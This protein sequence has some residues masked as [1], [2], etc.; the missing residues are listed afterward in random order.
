MTAAPG[1]A[2][3]PGRKEQH[4]EIHLGQKGGRTADPHRL[5]ISNSRYRIDTNVHSIGRR[6][7]W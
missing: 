2:V 4:E 7:Q 3:Y 6:T 1:R 5:E